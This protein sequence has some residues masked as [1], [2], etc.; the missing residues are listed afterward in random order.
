[1]H[2]KHGH[3]CFLLLSQLDS[4]TQPY[5]REANRVDPDIKP[6]LHRTVAPVLMAM[7]MDRAMAAAGR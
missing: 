4:L 1:V 5:R 7:Q 6:V 3:H 2:I